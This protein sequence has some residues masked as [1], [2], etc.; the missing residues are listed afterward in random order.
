M[1]SIIHCD[2]L[3]DGVIGEYYQKTAGDMLQSFWC[4]L[5]L[6]NVGDC[7]QENWIQSDISKWLQLAVCTLPQNVAANIS[8]WGEHALADFQEQFT[9]YLPTKLLH[10]YMNI[11]ANYFS[12][13]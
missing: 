4:R 2:Y 6:D 13:S 8:T 1:K 10:V 5:Y 9:L 11:C 7:F 12:V 3:C